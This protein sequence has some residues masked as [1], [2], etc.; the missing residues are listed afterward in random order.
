MV[1]EQLL[2]VVDHLE[3]IGRVG[4]V[5]VHVAAP[6]TAGTPQPGDRVLVHAD[7]ACDIE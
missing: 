7:R 4:T 3:I 1:V 6:P 2:D 5:R